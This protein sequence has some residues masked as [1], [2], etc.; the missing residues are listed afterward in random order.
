MTTI[1]PTR[2]TASAIARLIRATKAGNRSTAMQLTNDLTTTA[3]DAAILVT[4]LDQHNGTTT[5]IRALFTE[6]PQAVIDHIT[7]QIRAVK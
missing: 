7:T 5:D 3:R 4:V 2:T 1:T 6:G